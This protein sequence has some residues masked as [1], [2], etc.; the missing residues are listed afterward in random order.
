MPLTTVQR[1]LTIRI[2]VPIRNV[3]ML[4][5]SLGLVVHVVRSDTPVRKARAQR[6]QHGVRPPRG[7]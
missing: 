5:E 1:L 4:L 3:E 7:S 6:R 2:N